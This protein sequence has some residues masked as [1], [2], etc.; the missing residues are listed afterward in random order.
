MQCSAR[1][2][3]PLLQWSTPRPKTSVYTSAP[4]KMRMCCHTHSW[5]ADALQ[6]MARIAVSLMLPQLRQGQHMHSCI[7][8]P[9][10]YN[11]IF[12]MSLSVAATSSDTSHEVMFATDCLVQLQCHAAAAEC[13]SAPKGLSHKYGIRCTAA[14][15]CWRCGVVLLSTVFCDPTLQMTKACPVLQVVLQ[16]RSLCEDCQ[17]CLKSASMA[18][19]RSSAQAIQEIVPTSV[20][21]DCELNQ[22]QRTCLMQR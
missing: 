2:V 11:L 6:Q 4:I 17:P 15:E 21:G 3:T 20:D 18:V 1:Y 16:E 14:C 9:Q 5:F 22:L 7:P 13:T 8:E 12:F 19:S 10:V